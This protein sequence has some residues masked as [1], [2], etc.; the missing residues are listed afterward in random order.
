[1]TVAVKMVHR[2][3]ADQF[4]Y[5]E[6]RGRDGDEVRDAGRRF[7]TSLDSV[8]G[9]W[10]VEKMVDGDTLYTVAHDKEGT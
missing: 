5:A 3:D 8:R 9:A 7:L 10:F 4:D 6:F 2:P 1:M